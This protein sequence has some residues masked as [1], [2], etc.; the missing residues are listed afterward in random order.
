MV[1]CIPECL[2]HS[3]M[4][5]ASR[6]IQQAAEA[7]ANGG[8]SRMGVACSDRIWVVGNL[9]NT[10]TRSLVESEH[11]PPRGIRAGVPIHVFFMAAT[12]N[13]GRRG[14]TR[15]GRGKGWRDFARSQSAELA[16]CFCQVEWTRRAVCG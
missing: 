14:N 9:R 6:M 3:L 1:F 13:L 7:F 16:A 8:H 10:R 5:M 15:Q 2:F 11:P 4:A 12:G